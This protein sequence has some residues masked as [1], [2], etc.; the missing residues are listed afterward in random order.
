M[1]ILTVGNS[2]YNNTSDSAIHAD[3]LK[4]LK[5]EGHDVSAAVWHHVSSY[6]MFDEDEKY[7]FEDGEEKICELIVLP[8]E[9]SKVN[10]LYEHMKVF[11]PDAVISI[12]DYH[13]I[14]FVYAVKRLY[15]QLFKWLGVLTISSLPIKQ[16]HKEAL[17]YLD[18]AFC[19]SRRGLESFQSL[20]D[21]S[22][23]LQHFFPNREILEDTG[24]SGTFNV[25]ACLKNSQQSNLGT[26]LIVASGICKGHSDIKFYVHTNVDDDGDYDLEYMKSHL[27]F[28][29][30][31]VFPDKFVSFYDGIP[32]KELMQKFADADVFVDCSMTSAT[33]LSAFEAMLQGCIPLLSDT[34]A[35]VELLKF[36]QMDNHTGL[37]PYFA[38]DSVEFLGDKEGILNIVSQNE[39]YRKIMKTYKLWKEN[40]LHCMKLKTNCKKQ[41][42]GLMTGNLVKEIEK[43]TQDLV[44]QNNLVLAVDFLENKKDLRI[45]S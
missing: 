5:N 26:F 2:P 35:H 4:S 45:V 41:A 7:W 23:E 21:V 15:P 29:D 13:E 1:R 8:A 30:N 22:C 33:G 42:K 36:V 9:P 6:Y 37:Y 28:P 3:L 12:G 27:G 44:C 19:T 24:V 14:D 17:D 34:G 10:V 43:K 11:Q 40:P 31:L 39:L 25:V 20:T 32:Q 38:L 16:T 18:Y